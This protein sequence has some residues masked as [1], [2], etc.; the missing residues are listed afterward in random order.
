MAI[1]MDCKHEN[2][3]CFGDPIPVEVERM[4]FITMT[5]ERYKAKLEKAFKVGQ[6]IGFSSAAFN[7][8]L[9]EDDFENWLKTQER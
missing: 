7:T 8:P 2:C 4:D 1:C 9:K 6:A 5:K 3:R